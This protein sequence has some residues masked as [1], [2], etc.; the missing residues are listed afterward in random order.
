MGRT[1][2]SFFRVVFD[3]N[4]SCCFGISQIRMLILKRFSLRSVA[5][6]LIQVMRWGCSKYDD[7]V[8]MLHGWCYTQPLGMSISSADFAWSLRISLFEL[9]EIVPKGPM[10]TFKEWTYYPCQRRKCTKVHDVR[11]IMAIRINKAIDGKQRADAAYGN[12][13]YKNNN[14]WYSCCVFHHSHGTLN[15]VQVPIELDS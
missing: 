6:I 14:V 13:G 7:C 5:S 12:N 4:L 9:V 3:L 8:I 11:D 15:G 10:T 1:L 2:R